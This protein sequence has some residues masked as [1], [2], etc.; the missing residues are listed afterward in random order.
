VGVVRKVIEFIEGEGNALPKATM[1]PS[2]QVG[3][4]GW[5]SKEQKEQRVLCYKSTS[6]GCLNLW[7]G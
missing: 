6:K 2:G 5:R 4:V 1:A 7:M 3:Q